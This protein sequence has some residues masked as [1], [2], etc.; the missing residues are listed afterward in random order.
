MKLAIGAAQFG[1]PYGVANRVGQVNGESAAR[2]LSVA[3][4]NGID[5]IDTAA[6]YGES[7][8]VLGRAGVAGFRVVTKV[9][10]LDAGSDPRRHVRDSLARSLR[11]LGAAS[12]DALLLHR[13]LDLAESYGLALHAALCE[14]RDAGRVRRIGVSVYGPE[15]LG[16]IPDAMHLDVVQA[17]MSV[18]DRRMERSGWMDRLA[19]RGTAFHARSLFLQGL[20]L[21]EPARRPLRFGAW[22]S[23]LERWDRHVADSGLGAAGECLAAVVG[24]PRV[25][26]AVIGVDS[27][28]QLAEC[29]D[30]LERSHACEHPA[31]DSG[32]EPLPIGLIDP[33][34]WS[35]P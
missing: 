6:A 13:G 17:P 21:M 31:F 12:V 19:D 33:R 24:D 32:S 8:E 30:A 2:I 34:S 26:R 7:E 3:R 1:M 5:T 25:E 22:R 28:E 27:P 18:L 23:V 14:E 10:A 11:R 35:C 20:L 9:P 4:A 15:E 29:A 16:R